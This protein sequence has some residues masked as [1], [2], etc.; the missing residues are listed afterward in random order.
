MVDRRHWRTILRAE[1]V[2]SARNRTRSRQVAL[3]H[4][5]TNG[6]AAKASCSVVIP[7]SLEQYVTLICLNQ[8]YVAIHNERV[9]LIASKG[10]K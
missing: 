2:H 8:P 4:K 3:C 10:D 5:K 9:S 7:T 1:E 6:T